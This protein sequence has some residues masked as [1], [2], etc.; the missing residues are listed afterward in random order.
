[1]TARRHTMPPLLRRPVPLSAAALLLA[2]VPLPAQVPGPPTEIEAFQQL[3]SQFHAQ[4][5]LQSQTLTEQYERALARLETEVAEAGDYEQAMEIQK[6]REQLLALYAGNGGA[7]TGQPAIPLS[8]A[9]ARVTGLNVTDENALTGWRSA[10]H[11]AEW[12]NVKITPGEY[13]LEFEYLVLEAPQLSAAA[14][15]AEPRVTMEFFEVSLLAGAEDNRRGFELALARNAAAAPA[16]MR[17]GPVRYTRSPVTLRLRPERSYPGNLVRI[18]NLRLV[19]VPAP[20]PISTNGIPATTTGSPPPVPP[21]AGIPALR[22]RLAAA[23]ADAYQPIIASQ[24][25]RLQ[26]LAAQKPDWRPHIDAEVR[27]LQRRLDKPDKKDGLSLPKPIATLGGISGFQEWEDVLLLPHPENTGDRFRVRHQD[28]EVI[29]RL[30]WLRCAPPVSADEPATESLFSRHF[31]ISAED[32]AL[33]GRA[34]REFT[35]G[36]LDGKPLRLLVRATPDADGTVPALVFLDDIGLYHHVLID[37]GLAAV[38]GKTGT[39]GTLERALLRSLLEREAEARRRD[40][41]P[42]AWAL[43]PPPPTPP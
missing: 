25:A 36:Y 42:G 6:R 28:Q 38:T 39:G 1:M 17:V 15:A 7:V 26:G 12:S 3:R 13:F 43:S 32:A 4:A 19:P 30:L 41:R 14:P 18:Q 37:Q 20:P 29:V 27:N 24:I 5:L 9:E 40:P 31:D 22:E 23:L 35:S 33:F 11:S 8:A 16:P 21:P 10:S 34:A 2:G